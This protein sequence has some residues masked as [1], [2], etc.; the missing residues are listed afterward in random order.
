MDRL[1]PNKAS[2]IAVP[3]LNRLGAWCIAKDKA[4]CCKGKP[5]S[6]ASRMSIKILMES[7]EILISHKIFIVVV[8]VILCNFCLQSPVFGCMDCRGSSFGTIVHKCL[9]VFEICDRLIVELHEEPVK[10]RGNGNGAAA[11]RFLG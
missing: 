6:I 10:S 1:K 2:P 11:S 5:T 3:S 4:N 9:A 7:K 8:I